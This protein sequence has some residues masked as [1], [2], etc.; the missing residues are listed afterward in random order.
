[1]QARTALAVNIREQ[2]GLQ[3]DKVDIEPAHP[4]LHL[5]LPQDG[6]SMWRLRNSVKFPFVDINLPP[7]LVHDSN[8]A[9]G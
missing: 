6:D 4:P 3:G 5:N 2:S 7:R 9:S 1:V 8:C